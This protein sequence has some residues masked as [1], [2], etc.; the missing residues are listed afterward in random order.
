MQQNIN[1][2]PA[3]AIVKQSPRGVKYPPARRMTK[4]QRRE[5]AR[6]KITQ[7]SIERIEKAKQNA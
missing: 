2:L 6:Q 1:E 3:P 7:L 5:E 4:A